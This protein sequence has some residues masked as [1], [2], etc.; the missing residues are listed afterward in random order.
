MIPVDFDT[1]VA[2]MENN[3]WFQEVVVVL[4]A[5]KA[6]LLRLEA[7]NAQLK[8]KIASIPREE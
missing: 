3:I 7:E 1:W 2:G 6:E 8:N 4:K 5:M